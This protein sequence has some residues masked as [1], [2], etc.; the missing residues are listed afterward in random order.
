MRHI[1]PEN[2]LLVGS[3]MLLASVF[4]GKMSSRFG[5]PSLLLFLGVG[6]IMGSDGVGYHFD[7]A[8]TTQFVGIMALSVIL[9]SGGADTRFSEVRPVLREGIVLATLGVVLTA[10]LTGAFIWRVSGFFG[11]DLGFAESLL[12]ASVM[13]STDSASVFALLRSKGLSLRENLRA[14]LELESG[15]NDPMAY[16]LTV[17]LIQYIQGG[18]SL[19]SAFL[20]FFAQIVLGAALGVFFGYVV[21]WLANRAA[22]DNASL[23]SVLIVACVLFIFSATDRLG[24]NGYL[25]VYVSG[26]LFG[27]SKVAHLRNTKRFFSAFAW[28]WQII[29][30]LTLGLLVNPSELLPVSVFA[31]LIGVF[32]ILLGRPLSVLLCMA[33]FRTYSARGKIYISWVGLRGAVPIIFATYPLVAGVTEARLMFNVVFFITILSLAVQGMTVAKMAF[34]LKVCGKDENAKSNLDFEL[35]DEMK[36][37]IS[38]IDVT[39][40]LLSGGDTLAS[41][42]LPPKTLVIMVGR[43]GGYFIPGGASKLCKG[44]KLFVISHDESNLKSVCEKLNVPYY[45]MGENS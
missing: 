38:E 9:F 24:G 42:S 36:S 17:V 44:D 30:F 25:A 37:V 3:G 8:Y 10:L 2:I 39:E 21:V 18:V 4:A 7:N 43:G 40:T 1:T 23:Y 33:P 32:L 22:F 45:T 12:L 28:L 11:F 15:S 41:L 31:L 14:T 20:M 13:S 19:D 29:M 6:M 34:W 26:L 35:P 27:N 5:I 16:I